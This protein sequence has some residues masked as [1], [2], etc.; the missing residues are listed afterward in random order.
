MESGIEI[1]DHT[2]TYTIPSGTATQID[3]E[4]TDIP[5]EY[6]RVV[7]ILVYPHQSSFTLRLGI[8][9]GSRTIQQLTHPDDW[10]SS[11]AVAHEQ[12]ARNV[13]FRADLKT[14]LS[15]EPLAA[16]GADE[17][18]DIVFRCIK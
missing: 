4:I 18:F 12:R 10:R 14:T 9:Q 13:S 6:N 17:T 11:N 3:K 8:S 5:K 7:G 16:L 2:V 15:I 1:Y